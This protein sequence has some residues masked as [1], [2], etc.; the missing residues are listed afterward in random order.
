MAGGK[1]LRVDYQVSPQLRKTLA[2][3]RKRTGNLAPLHKRFGEAALGW[4]ARNFE[5]EG[6]PKWKPLSRNTLAGRRMGSG[7]ILQNTGIHLKNTFRYRH[8]R[9]AVRVGTPSKIARY[10]EEGTGPYEIKPKHGSVLVFP[11]AGGGNVVQAG[12]VFRRAVAVDLKSGKSQYRTRGGG[13][14]RGGGQGLGVFRKV[15]HPGLTARPML[16]T[17]VQ[18]YEEIQLAEIAREYLMEVTRGD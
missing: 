9:N 7:K 6:S 5:R 12:G 10:H 17:Q 3:L 2:E 16:P 4:I 13:L 14:S 1:G 11:M 15:R 8:D 18:V